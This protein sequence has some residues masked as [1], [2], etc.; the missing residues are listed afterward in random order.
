MKKSITG[1]CLTDDPSVVSEFADLGGCFVDEGQ[2]TIDHA[3]CSGLEQRVAAIS[4]EFAAHL[5]IVRIETVIPDE[6]MDACRVAT[7][8]FEPVESSQCSLDEEISTESCLFVS[9]IAARSSGQI[10]HGARC[11]KAITPD[12]P[13]KITCRNDALGRRLEGIG[14]GT[15]FL[16]SDIGGV[17]IGLHESQTVRDG[18]AERTR[19]QRPQSGNPLQQS[20]HFGQTAGSA[21][22]IDPGFDRIIEEFDDGLR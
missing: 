14:I 18:F 7:T 12:R 4:F 11:L 15:G 16:E 21:N 19:R 2:D 6:K 20:I 5:R 9:D 13:Q 1:D 10:S 8:H 22:E 3:D 17:D